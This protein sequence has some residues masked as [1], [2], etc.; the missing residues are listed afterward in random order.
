[1]QHSSPDALRNPAVVVAFSGWNDAGNAASDIVA[2]L[3]A[4]YPGFDVG[5][6]DGERYYD[7]QAARPM[8]HRA[9]DGPWIEWPAIRFRVVQH[10]DRDLVVVVGPEPN[11]LWRTFAAE[12]IGH[13]QRVEPD[14]VVFLGAMLSDTPHSR[15]LGFQK[16]L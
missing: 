12:L 4:A 16:Y 11:L 14:I 5:T 8:L 9:A 6:I 1:M 7:F 3:I 13:V 2:H 10:P 15:P